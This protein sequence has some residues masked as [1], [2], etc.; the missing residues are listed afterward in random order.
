MAKLVTLQAAC[1]IV[2]PMFLGGANPDNCAELRP[3]SIKGALRFWWRALKW[4]K[5]RTSLPGN[6]QAFAKLQTEEAALFG[7][8]S[9]GQSQVLL[10][11]RH[12]INTTEIKRGE[13]FTKVAIDPNDHGN[14]TARPGARYLGYG[15]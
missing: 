14:G 4:A 8:A 1:R 11:I 6:T 12:H 9:G 7:S 3:P 5:I 15:V 13:V 10:H 2:T